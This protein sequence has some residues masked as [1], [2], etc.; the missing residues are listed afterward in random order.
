[1]SNSIFSYNIDFIEV[2]PEWVRIGFSVITG[3]S[4]QQ[5]I[6]KKTC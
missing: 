3:L 4:I 2:L 1:M 5:N 6:I